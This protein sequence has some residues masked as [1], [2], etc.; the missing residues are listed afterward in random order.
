MEAGPGTEGKCRGF[1]LFPSE[2][3]VWIVLEAD[4]ENCLLVVTWIPG[5]NL[6]VNVSSDFQKG[7]A[8]LFLKV[9]QRL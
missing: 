5:F 3:T 2:T 7:L 1:S 9:K 4:H 6:R 8:W